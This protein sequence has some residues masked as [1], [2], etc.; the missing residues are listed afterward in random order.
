MFALYLP[1]VGVFVLEAVFGVVVLF[2]AAHVNA[3]MQ[4]D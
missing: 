2:I 1:W 3:V 4:K